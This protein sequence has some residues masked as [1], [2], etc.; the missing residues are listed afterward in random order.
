ME[1]MRDEATQVAYA[2][3]TIGEAWER[4]TGQA[5]GFTTEVR[6]ATKA[7]QEADPEFTAF[8]ESLAGV[9]DE[10]ERMIPYIGSLIADLEKGTI[11]IPQFNEALAQMRAG[12]I[13]IQGMSGHMFGDLETE[14]NKL[15]KIINDFLAGQRGRR[16]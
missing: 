7:V 9:S 14:F 2:V 12:F 13:Q 3:D 4:A 15:Q 8:V 16:K 6:T 11:T 1:R 10:Y 5:A